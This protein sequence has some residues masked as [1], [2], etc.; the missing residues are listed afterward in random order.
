MKEMEITLF[1]SLIE[2][3]NSLHDCMAKFQELSL[4]TFWL[5]SKSKIIFSMILG[6]YIWSRL[7]CLFNEIMALT[8]KLI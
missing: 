3:M 2:F 8:N 6:N 5:K 4:N 7:S 1:D